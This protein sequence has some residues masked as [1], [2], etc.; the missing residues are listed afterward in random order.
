LPST[1]SKKKPETAIAAPAIA[2][3]VADV[4]DAELDRLVGQIREL[5]RDATFMFV[6]ALGQLVVERFYNGDLKAW[7][8]TGAKDTSF[9]KLAARLEAEDGLGLDHS[10]LS[11]AVGVYELVSTVQAVA[12]SQHLRVGHYVAVLGLPQKTA[13][14][15]LTK[16]DAERWPVPRVRQEAAKHRK[17]DGRGRKPKLPF[18]KGIQRLQAVLDHKDELFVGLERVEDVKPEEV[19]GLFS[20]LMSLGDE[21]ERLKNALRGRT[22]A[23]SRFRMSEAFRRFASWDRFQKHVTQVRSV[24]SD[25]STLTFDNVIIY[26]FFM[27]LTNEEQLRTSLDALFFRDTIL[28]RLKALGVQ[29]LSQQFPRNPKEPTDAYFDRALVWISNTFGGYSISHVSGRFKAGGIM[30]I[31]Q[32]AQV[33]EDGG[34]YLIDETTAI[35]RFVF[36]V[37]TPAKQTPP[38]TSD[39]FFDAFVQ[40]PASSPATEAEATRIRWFFG[41]LFVQ[42]IVQVI[43]GEAEIWMLESGEAPPPHLESGGVDPLGQTSLDDPSNETANALAFCGLMSHNGAMPPYQPSAAVSQAPSGAPVVR[44]RIAPN[45]MADRGGLEFESTQAVNT[46]H[47]RRLALAAQAVRAV[48]TMGGETPRAV[49]DVYPTPALLAHAISRRVAIATGA[50]DLVIEPSAGDGVFVRAAR[51]AWGPSVHIHAVEPRPDAAVHHLERLATSCELGTWENSARA[52]VLLQKHERALI[53]GNPP[54]LL[55]E[56]HVRVSLAWLGH[57]N[58]AGPQPRW[59]AFLLRSSFL[60]GDKRAR[61]LH[62]AL[63]GLRYVWNVVGRPSFTGDGKTDGAEYACLVWQAGWQGPYEG[64]WLTWKESGPLRSV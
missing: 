19:D 13:E 61:R 6:M 28:A 31:A 54:F 17:S 24:S 25:Y 16:A 37:G 32:S 48:N 35:A 30:T 49:G 14:K 51:S 36:P 59:L 53:L 57:H 7:R 39:H 15:L 4:T 52:K 50:V 10:S 11:R 2:A 40:H 38:L 42:S 44:V 47:E 62:M 33:Q 46:S 18:V 34:R 3:V 5:K 43:N 58:A 12:T 29:K 20:T 64:G 26:E 45:E 41:V 56:E 9:R 63:G 1:K 60:A 23:G 55:A 27:P 21:V 22:S 8:S